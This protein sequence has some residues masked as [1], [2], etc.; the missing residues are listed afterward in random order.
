MIDKT[1]PEFTAAA[2]L[3]AFARGNAV[4]LTADELFT[5]A[6][7][8][9]ERGDQVAASL[10]RPTWPEYYMGFA[11]H[12]ARKSKDPS[13]KVGCAVIGSDGEV[14]MTGY[15]GLPRGVEDKPE[16]MERPAKYLWTSHAEENAVAFAAR[17]GASLAG[18]T[19]F[20]TH[21]PCSRCARMLIQAGVAAVVVG[22]GTTSM[23]KEEFVVAAQAFA[24][25]DVEVQ[26]LCEAV[27]DEAG[28]RPV[29]WPAYRPEAGEFA[30]LYMNQKA[31]T[32]AA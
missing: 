7:L 16:R 5:M 24:E 18:S 26:I 11:T 8:L 28:E 3:R 25:A 23:P 12:A 21:H 6:D 4:D 17:K 1:L 19:F 13:T 14:I 32:D 29:A 30:T 27:E 22:P 31:D 9:Q 15:N 10:R 20:V 2:R